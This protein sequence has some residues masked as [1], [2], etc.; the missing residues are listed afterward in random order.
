M[1]SAVPGPPVAAL[2]LNYQRSDLTLQCLADLLRLADEPLA[3]AVLDNG[4]RD[5]SVDRLRAGINALAPSDHRVEL[6]ANAENLGFAAGMNV[7]IAWAAALG[8]EFT[9]VLNNDLRLTEPFVHCLA[10]CLRHDPRLAAVGPTVLHADGTVWAQG[11]ELAFAPNALRLRGH[12]GPPAARTAGP[13]EVG[14]LPAACVLY[15]SRALVAVGGF[16]PRYFM[17]WED[18]VL[19]ARLRAQGGGIV[20]LPWVRVVHASGASS[21]GRRSE[22]RKYLMAGYAVA[23]LREVGHARAWLAWLLFDVLLWPLALVG[24]VRPAL[25][26]LR[27][28]LAG[29]RGHLPTRS[30]LT[31]YLS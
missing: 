30:D 15:R 6:L 26:K 19:S 28:T 7:G 27:G 24:G 5:G 20:W 11:G 14:F 21:G 17:Y 4:S 9:L 3:I 16:D 23:A 22:L 2:L 29:L 31:R 1:A 18:V 13:V 25:A 8:C 12:G 10:Q